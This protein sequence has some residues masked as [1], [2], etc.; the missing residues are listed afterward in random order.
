MRCKIDSS[1][2]ELNKLHLATV[3]IPDENQIRP[4]KNILLLKQEKL[5]VI[6][7]QWESLKDYINCYVWGFD[8]SLNESGRF[9]ANFIP[10]NY[11][12][13]L[14]EF[15]YD[16]HENVKHCVLWFPTQ[17]NI[18][19]DEEITSIITIESEKLYGDLIEFVWYI[20]PKMTVPDYFHVQ[21]FVYTTTPKTI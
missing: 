2:E 13:Q 12:F 16:L 11:V 15:P 6:S 9:I 21:V 7:H 14:C 10:N 1:F 20:N 3:W 4:K 5:S 19:S 8:R 18:Y 17:T